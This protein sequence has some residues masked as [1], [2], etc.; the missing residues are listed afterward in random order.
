MR[1]EKFSSETVEAKRRACKIAQE[2][3]EGDDHFL[4]FVVELNT[5]GNRI[6]A[7]IWDTEFHVFGVIAS[8]TDHIPL[9]SVRKYSAKR[10]LEKCDAEMKEIIDFY[11]KEIQTACRDI[12]SK[13]GNA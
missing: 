9:T 5:L 2:L 10:W 1:S 12:I 6:Y 7:E 13:H 8:D 4:D 11:R 3:I